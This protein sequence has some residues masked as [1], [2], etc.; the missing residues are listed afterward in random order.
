MFKTV[1]EFIKIFGPLALG[2]C[3]VSTWFLYTRNKSHQE[4]IG[5]RQGTVVAVDSRIIAHDVALRSSDAKY[6]ARLVARRLSAQPE[7]IGLRGIE[8]D[9]ADFAR[10][11]QSY[12]LLRFLDETGMERIR[13]S[14]SFAG[15]VVN[16]LKTMQNKNDRYYFQKTMLAGKDDVY[17]SHFDLNI[18]HRYVERPFK[19]TLRFAC[20]VID[21]AGQKKGIV[22]LNFNGSSLLESLEFQATSEGSIPMLTTSQGHWI[23]A[24]DPADEWGHVL[25]ETNDASMPNRFPQA[26]DKITNNEKGQVLT[27]HGLFTFDTIDVIP[28]SV[29]SK[30]PPSP[31][32]AKLRWKILTWV[33]LAQLTVLW[34]PLFI[35]LVAMALILLSFG[36]WHLAGY[37]INQSEI[38]I[39][40][41]ENEERTMAISQSSQDAIAM[42]DGQDQITYWNPAAEQLF[43]YAAE[44]MLGQKLH[45]LLAPMELRPIAK[46]ALTDFAVNGKGRSVGNVLEFDALHKDGSLVPVE[47]S[48]SSFRLK[49]KWYAVGS[50]RDITRR[51]Q[52]ELKL[53]RSEETSRALINAPTESAMLI[54]PNGTIVAINKV[55]AHKLGSSV[56]KMIGQNAYAVIS[57]D[58]TGN[59][60][61]IFKQVLETAEP[62]RFEHVGGNRLFLVNVYPTKT[63]DGSV[64][65]LA[66]FARDVT[67]QREAE[68][69]LMLSEQRFRDVSEAVGEYIWETDEEGLFKLL[70]EDVVSVLGYTAEELTG[71]PSFDL[72]PKEDIK[73]YNTWQNSIYGKRESFTNIELRNITKDG[74]TIWMQISGVP[75]YDEKRKFLGYRGAGM[76]ITDRK[77]AENAVKTSERKL[78][79]L[80]KSAYDAII[81]IDTNGCV[82]F[83]N[84]AAEKLF[85]Y[86]ESEALGKEIHSMIAPPEERPK[87][88]LGMY[89]FAMTGNGPAVGRIEETIALHKDGTRIPVERSVSGFQLGEDWHAVAT[90]RDITERKELEAKLRKLATT[91][92]LTGLYNRRRFME[93]SEREFTRSLRY[94]R[95][96]VMFM[97]D[98]DHFKKVNDTYGHDIGDM[99]LRSLSKTTLIALRNADILGRLGGEEF[100]VLLPETGKDTAVEI[101]ERLRS[102]IEGTVI[103]ANSN[104]INITI[105]LGVACLDPKTK[106]IEQLL[107]RADVALY[108]AKQS[109]RNRSVL[110]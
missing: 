26:W 29:I 63:P 3:L 95:P 68:R 107:K 55:G 69:A 13:L 86:K 1:K 104:N 7:T 66:I 64:D 101:A 12:Y 18:E 41:R 25:E 6:L 79:A 91:D 62:A 48:V 87:A 57:P 17:I 59:R 98:I 45:D 46:K 88:E 78:R 90:V 21:D 19:P 42:V 31:D 106:N 23:I 10:S 9:F 37:R 105:S 94:N 60:K 76:N 67:E 36:C 43:G 20:P 50:M 82:S 84:H 51:K 81:T 85:G 2:V 34:M 99:V 5:Q 110:G 89:E 53:K 100:G 14:R 92:S 109:G 80:A 39:R 8:D 72:M 83:W 70:T 56:G 38:E 49:E 65:R 108:K 27:S 71:R 58:L 15:P 54:E 61:D 22:V 103:S 93:L 77:A 75:Y 16:T 32:E 33:P 74:R 52:N 44:E 4:L 24:A 28:G 97:M 40:L 47:L 35:F 96:L 102:S 73:D 11:R 30:S